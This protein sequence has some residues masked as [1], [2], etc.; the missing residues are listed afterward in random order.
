[1]QQHVHS[2]CVGEGGGREH[3]R[4]GEDAF[5]VC[6]DEVPDA[7]GLQKVVVEGTVWTMSLCPGCR[8]RSGHVLGGKGIC[9]EEDAFLHFLA[10]AGGATVSIYVR[11]LRFVGAWWRLPVQT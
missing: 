1:M 2:V 9:A 7:L 10:E 4:D 6:T 8:E 11:R 3:V 5:E